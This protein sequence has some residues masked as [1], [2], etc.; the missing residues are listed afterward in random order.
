[1]I[2]WILDC[3]LYESW[4]KTIIKIEIS[5]PRRKIR[6]CRVRSNIGLILRHSAILCKKGADCHRKSRHVYP[7][8]LPKPSLQNTPRPLEGTL[9]F[10]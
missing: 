5:V 1:M 4:K 8:H 7:K 2:D 10:I 3:L 9:H 6:V